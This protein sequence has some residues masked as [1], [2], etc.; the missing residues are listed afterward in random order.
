MAHNGTTEDKQ[1]D[2]TDELAHNAG[3][4][5][6]YL[7][8]KG[9]RYPLGPLKI[10]DTIR[11]EDEVGPLAVHGNS[12]RGILWQLYLAMIRGGM[13]PEEH[14]P[15][16]LA[17]ELDAAQIPEIVGKL[18]SLTPGSEDGEEGNGPEA[19]EGVDLVGGA[20]SSGP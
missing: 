10:A 5:R 6:V 12:Q 20:G 11:I 15:A 1:L 13:D 2:T 9:E 16:E 3:V 18:N 19:D 7:D 8:F 4:P 17:E 14:K